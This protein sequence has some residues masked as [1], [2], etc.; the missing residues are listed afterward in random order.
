MAQ[1]VQ[2]ATGEEGVLVFADGALVA[3]LSRLPD[4]LDDRAGHWFIECGFGRLYGR[5]D[6][7]ARLTDALGWIGSQ[8]SPDAE[9][10]CGGP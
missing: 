5:Y 1:P 8:I 3:V 2:I 6:D 9:G 4:D 10:A 7:F